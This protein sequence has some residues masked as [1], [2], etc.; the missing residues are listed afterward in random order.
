MNPVDRVGPVFDAARLRSLLAVV[1]GHVLSPMDS[2][3][4]VIIDRDDI[5]ACLLGVEPPSP[6]THDTPLRVR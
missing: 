2:N 3:R 1:P 4:T 5:D 6:Q